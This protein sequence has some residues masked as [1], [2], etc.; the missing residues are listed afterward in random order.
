MEPLPVLECVVTCIPLH[1]VKPFA[2]TTT[3]DDSHWGLTSKN[4]VFEH[5][6]THLYDV[7]LCL[8]RLRLFPL[9]AHPFKI[10]VGAVRPNAQSN[11]CEQVEYS[12][13]GA[14]HLYRTN[15]WRLALRS[16]PSMLRDS[17]AIADECSE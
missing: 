4:D 15:R 17:C 14:G 8:E 9:G 13:G 2:G 10:N 11:R 6:A 5:W 1:N 12:W 3:K 16:L 7:R